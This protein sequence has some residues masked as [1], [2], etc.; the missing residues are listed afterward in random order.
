MATIN[1]DSGNNNLV[2]TPANDTLN[3]GAG[4]DT[5][6]GGEGNDVYIV[7]STTDTIIEYSSGGTH[8]LV[9]S[10]VSYTLTGYLNDLTLTG[11]NA[12]NGT[13]NDFDISLR[14]MMPLTLSMVEVAKIL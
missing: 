7:D 8:D 9:R 13:G 1:G 3:G 4:V 6:I 5:L 12:I 2:G 11:T 10:S 14:V